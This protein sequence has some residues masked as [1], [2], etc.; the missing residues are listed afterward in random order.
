MDWLARVIDLRI[1]LLPDGGVIFDA[2]L[3][4]DVVLSV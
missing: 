1:A 3:H 4:A 2:G